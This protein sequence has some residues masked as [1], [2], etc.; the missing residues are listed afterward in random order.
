MISAMS[1]PARRWLRRFTLGSGPLKR[2]SDRVQVAGRIVLVVSVLIAPSLAVAAGTAATAHYESVAASQWEERS[3]VTAVLLEDPP[4][5]APRSYGAGGGTELPTVLVRA[6][7]PLPEGGS[8]EGRVP[9]PPQASAGTQVPVW[10]D[11]E[12]R[13]TTAPLDRARIADWEVMTAA[14][15]L[16]GVPL[17]TWTLYAVLCAVLDARRQ[18]R[19][20]RDW[21]AVEPSWN[22]H[23]P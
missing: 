7:W 9:V 19:W 22:P 17:L 10:I 21:A 1:S 20:A 11:R 5:T 3:R 2:S 6:S 15:P 8:R 18:R 23:L 14:L 4:D 13:L 12:G 16:F